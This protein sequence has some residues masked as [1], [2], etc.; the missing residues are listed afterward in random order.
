LFPLLDDPSLHAFI[1][2]EPR[3]R[4]ELERWVSTV[5]A[6]RSPS[7]DE[8][9][10]N[11]IVRS[12]QDGSA[13][14]T[15]QATIVDGEASLAWVTGTAWHGLGYAKESAAAVAAWLRAHGIERLRANI[16]PDHAASN[17]VARSIGLA[18]T[19]ERFEGEVVWRSNRSG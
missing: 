16:H 2:G 19:D 9:W 15:A 17:A 13:V 7:G 1:G 3:R 5:V 12:S 8:I 10:C 14:G 6:G 11:W 4:E 18:P